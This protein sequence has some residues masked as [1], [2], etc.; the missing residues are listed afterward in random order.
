[1]MENPT[2]QKNYS[3]GSIV[4]KCAA[5]LAAA[6]RSDIPGIDGADRAALPQGKKVGLDASGITNCTE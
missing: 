1:M 6:V 5:R 2:I 4:A 3:P